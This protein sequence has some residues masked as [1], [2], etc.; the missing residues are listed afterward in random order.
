M[1]F[2]DRSQAFVRFQ[3]YLY[4]KAEEGRDIFG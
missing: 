1:G 4:L 2:T 3:K